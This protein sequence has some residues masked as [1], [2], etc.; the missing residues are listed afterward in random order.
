MGYQSKYVVSGPDSRV[1][2]APGGVQTFPTPSIDFDSD[3][4]VVL[5]WQ[6][7]IDAD[8][9]R[10]G[11]WLTAVTINGK[12]V[13]AMKDRLTRNLLNKPLSFKD[14]RGRVQNWYADLA[15]GWLTPFSPDFS[16]PGPMT[17]F[18]NQGIEAYKYEVDVT[19]L[20]R[21]IG[22]NELVIRN[23]MSERYRQKYKTGMF[24]KRNGDLVIQEI[25]IEIRNDPKRATRQEAVEKGLTTHAVANQWSLEIEQSGEMVISWPNGISARMKSSFANGGGQWVE[26]PSS[27]GVQSPARIS[28]SQWRL[29]LELPYYR[30]ERKI[31]QEKKKIRITDR[32]ISKKPK[33]PV[34]VVPRYELHVAP[35]RYGTAWLGGD[36][37]PVRND[38]DSPYNPTLFVPMDRGGVGL[39][40]VDDVMRLQG[41]YSYDPVS[42]TALIRSDELVVSDE[43]KGGYEACIDVYPM[44]S[45]D[46]WDFINTVRQDWGVSVTLPGTIW[47]TYPENI[48][49]S[50]ETSVEG[51]IRYNHVAYVIFWQDISLK[52]H[53]EIK[54]PYFINGA[55]RID[56]AFK[57]IQAPY[58][59]R[60]RE[61]IECIHRLAPG[62]KVLLY[63]H[64]HV[65]SVLDEDNLG[66]ISGAL[67]TDE[68]NNRIRRHADDNR[69]YP[70]FFV[71]P[72]K[73]N[74]YGKKFT[75][76]V[77]RLLGLGSDGIYWDEM[78][79]AS[80]EV[81]FTYSE[82]DGFTADIDMETQTVKKRKG[83]VGLLS[84]PYKLKLINRLI[85]EGRT[86]HANGA[87]ELLAFNQLPITRMVETPN[88]TLRTRELHL[89]TPYAYTWGPFTLMQFRDR[90]EN[91]SLCLRPATGK[92]F[93]SN[94]YPITPQSIGPGFVIGSERIVAAES[95]KYGWDGPWHAEMTLYNEEGYLT[96]RHRLKATGKESISVPKNGLVI[97][98]REN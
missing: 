21:S 47:F 5:A 22:S 40:V 19:D 45:V 94:A 59:K 86:V 2:V 82:F 62:T 11:Q 20:I 1:R 76:L 9:L 52:Y 55:S 32:I 88:T 48:L 74:G 34:V 24:E 10:I 37:D 95:G 57:D 42:G 77:D 50:H 87:P 75:R 49:L 80:R 28:P 71:Y 93:I 35:A 27:S 41:K 66:E 78:S 85:S 63:V 8:R 83:L 29:N 64:S 81:K 90:L 58:E 92:S 36:P 65:C 43:G 84:A 70:L 18:H 26:I 31:H 61:A 6:A 15:G 54:E 98:A 79:A 39:V 44:Q 46:Y 51:F 23:L 30:V 56:E 14:H 17:W 96:G 12:P 25:T 33:N 53:S 38:V 67:I 68:N 3:Q 69:F 91:A 13:V 60:V 4:H 73:N 89:T 16:I 7:R 97:L 72:T